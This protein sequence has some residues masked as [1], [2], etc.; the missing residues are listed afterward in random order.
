LAA[1]CSV[2]IQQI[3]PVVNSTRGTALKAD[4][5]RHAGFL[6]FSWAYR[7]HG[8]D[9]I[10]HRIDRMRTQQPNEIAQCKPGA[11]PYVVSLAK[12]S[13]GGFQAPSSIVGTVN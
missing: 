5:T 12:F 2:V 10:A 4:R 7:H 11:C 9:D 13:M 6:A 8:Y 3:V 1:V